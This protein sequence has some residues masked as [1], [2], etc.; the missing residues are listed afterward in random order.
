MTEFIQASTPDEIA[1]ARELFREYETSLDL[2]LCFQ[3]F[4]EE[5]STLPGRYAPPD[6][7][8][9]LLLDDDEHAGCVAMRKL[10]EG[11]CEMKRLY[12]RPRFRGRGLGNR[13]IEKVIAEARAAGYRTMRLDTLP[14]KMGKAVSIYTSYGFRA[15][16]PYYDNPHEGVLF[17]ELDLAENN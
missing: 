16:Q 3:G 7:R 14:P 17:M 2:D 1:A 9:I 6:G 8:L 13:L 4:E 5:L 11:V 10:D 12:L 15:I